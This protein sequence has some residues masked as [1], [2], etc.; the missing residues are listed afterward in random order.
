MY[1]QKPIDRF[2]E[3]HFEDC[4][5]SAQPEFLLNSTE[6][7]DQP[8]E[9]DFSGQ[10][11]EEDLVYQM[12]ANEEKE[13]PYCVNWSSTRELSEAI[14]GTLGPKGNREPTNLRKVLPDLTHVGAG[15]SV[16]VHEEQ[17][18]PVKAAF[19]R[20][21][22]SGYSIGLWYPEGPIN[23]ENIWKVAETLNAHFVSAIEVF[24]TGFNWAVSP[25]LWN[26]MAVRSN[27]QPLV[28]ITWG[29]PQDLPFTL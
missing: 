27:V 20:H 1:L 14:E 23:V 28:Q 7:G 3:D 26:Q 6:D 24:P 29:T 13:R 11:I 19:C 5:L 12:A 18:G 2:T 21:P 15:R 8:P 17:P 9:I 4:P 25:E 10:M 22:G 16:P